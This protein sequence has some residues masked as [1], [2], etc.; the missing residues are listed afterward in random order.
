MG[1]GR[2]RSSGKGGVSRALARSD[3]S[4]SSAR[5]EH[6]RRG[7]MKGDKF[8]SKKKIEVIVKWCVDVVIKLKIY[9]NLYILI[10]R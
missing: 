5:N 3:S 4:E 8:K 2:S 7:Q 9:L 1:R 6:R 10:I